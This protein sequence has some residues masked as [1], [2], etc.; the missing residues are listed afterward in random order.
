MTLSPLRGDW[1]PEQRQS[2][3][4]K[5]RSIAS[6]RPTC[7]WNPPMQI[8]A[9]CWILQAISRW[10]SSAEP[11]KRLYQHEASSWRQKRSLPPKLPM[12]RHWRDGQKK[13]V[14]L[15]KLAPLK[16]QQRKERHI[17][18]SAPTSSCRCRW[19]KTGKGPRQ[20]QTSVR[21]CGS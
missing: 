7:C 20:F 1:P 12:R 15:R 11:L 3:G 13:P 16:R 18:P 17:R 6:T 19:S 14:M 5:F 2:F 10:I 8:G 9:S 4:R 21:P